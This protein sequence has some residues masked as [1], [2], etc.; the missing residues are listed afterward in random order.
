MNGPAGIRGNHP[1]RRALPMAG[2]LCLQL[3][4]LPAKSGAEPR[5]PNPEAGKGVF[6]QNC[7]VCHGAEGRGDGL[8]AAGLPTR[9]ANFAE[10]P[11]TEERQRNIVANGGAAEKLSPVMPA[12][13]ATLS[14]QQIR[15][16][17]AYVRTYLVGS[18]QASK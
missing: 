16:V 1:L 15:D 18:R 12:W 17:V 3:A 5:V 7:V 6:A 9:P 10:R 8:A 11:S 2:A 14:D 13:G 4:L